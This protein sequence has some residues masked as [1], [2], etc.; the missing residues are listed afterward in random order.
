MSM[1]NTLEWYLVKEY[2]SQRM[3]APHLKL[4]AITLGYQEQCLEREP[5]EQAGLV[6]S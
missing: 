6:R 5:G 1:Y 3:P 4:T 2:M